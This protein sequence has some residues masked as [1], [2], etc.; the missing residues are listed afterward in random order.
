MKLA[1]GV[2]AIALLSSCNPRNLK[3]DKPYF[4]FDSL[5]H[6]QVITIGAANGS[7]H[8]KTFMNGRRDSTTFVP[9]TASWKRELDVFVQLD[10]INKPR[11]KDNYLL[12]LRPDDH[13]NLIMHTYTPK[14]PSSVKELKFF[15][16]EG[17]R[18]LRK[19]ESNFRDENILFSTARK[20]SLEFDDEQGTMVITTFKVDGYQKMI[21]SDS[22]KFAILGKVRYP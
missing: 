14:I 5:V 1:F 12:Q 17:S 8:K 7:L 15:Y 22:V 21:F 2:I 13:S 3:Y 10:L 18:K 20:L 11:Y 6:A 19:I 9:D 16:Q 4:D